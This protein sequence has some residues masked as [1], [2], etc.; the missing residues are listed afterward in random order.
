VK[1]GGV[2]NIECFSRTLDGR[3]VWRK[4]VLAVQLSAQQTERRLKG[5]RMNGKRHGMEILSDNHT[6]ALVST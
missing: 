3:G 4:R 2:T 1:G 5:R 6:E